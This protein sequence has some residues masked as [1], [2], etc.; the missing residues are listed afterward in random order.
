MKYGEGVRDLARTF[1]P[2]CELNECCLFEF[3][4]NL[5]IH[6][7]THVSLHLANA[8]VYLELRPLQGFLS[9]RVVEKL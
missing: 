5:Y 3:L 6:S 2:R 1:Q 4:V 8:T 7:K 9:C